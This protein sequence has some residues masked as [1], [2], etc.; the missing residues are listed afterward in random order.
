MNSLDKHLRTNPEVLPSAAAEESW[1]TSMTGVKD[2]KASLLLYEQIMQVCLASA[3]DRGLAHGS[4][5][6]LLQELAPA[7]ALEGLLV[8][9]MLAC[10][11]SGMEQLRKAVQSSSPEK[12]DR[13]LRHAQQL[14]KLFLSQVDGLERLRGRRHQQVRV[15]HVHI[16]DGGQAIVG[17]VHSSGV[18]RV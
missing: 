14:Q 10:H 11:M 1:L 9:Q 2:D 6:A 4:I 8:S 13:H 15:E 16:H 18:S 7:S 3:E 17:T 5:S 12:A